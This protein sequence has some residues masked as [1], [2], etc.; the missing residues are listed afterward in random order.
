MLNSQ[1]E[2]VGPSSYNYSPRSRGIGNIVSTPSAPHSIN[3]NCCPTFDWWVGISSSIP[4]LVKRLS[5]VYPLTATG[6][7]AISA[8]TPFLVFFAISYDFILASS[9]LR[10][11]DQHKENRIPLLFK[12]SDTPRIPINGKSNGVFHFLFS[13]LTIIASSVI[14]SYAETSIIASLFESEI[15]MYSFFSLSLI[16]RLI[17]SVEK[18]SLANIAFSLDNNEHARSP[19][20]TSNFSFFGMKITNHKEYL[21]FF[22]L[23]TSVLTSFSLTQLFE[24]QNEFIWRF[25]FVSMIACSSSI[26]LLADNYRT[27]RLHKAKINQR[28]EERVTKPNVFLSVAKLILNL[29]FLSGFFDASTAL[30]ETPCLGKKSWMLTGAMFLFSI[31]IAALS[32]VDTQNLPLTNQLSI[33]ELLMGLSL[34]FLVFSTLSCIRPRIKNCL[35]VLSSSLYDNLI[36]SCWTMG[37]IQSIFP[38]IEERDMYSCLAFLGALFFFSIS[39]THVSYH[40]DRVLAQN[41]LYVKTTSNDIRYENVAALPERRGVSHSSASVLVSQDAGNERI[42]Y[43]ST[44]NNKPSQPNGKGLS[45]ISGPQYAASVSSMAI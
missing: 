15:F 23:Y 19:K 11:I 28:K 30:N 1:A 42:W 7:P 8:T 39:T 26:T 32:L 40:N 12:K 17:E 14:F 34:V 2:R 3:L 38:K 35:E 43:V 44:R 29:S 41:I 37:L 22:R 25:V 36:A 21:S 45:F 31:S 4:L 20:L 10:T 6:I 9:W 5:L 33:D 18:L 13:I 24:Y 16:G 27:N